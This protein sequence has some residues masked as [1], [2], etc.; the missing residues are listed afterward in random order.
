MSGLE[1]AGLILGAILVAIETLKI[2]SQGIA[3]L[4]RSR[5]YDYELERLINKL[6]N[7]R[8]R[9][10]DVCEKVLVDLVPHSR[11]EDLIQHPGHLF[12]DD[13][14]LKAKLRRR[15]WKGY[16]LFDQTLREINATM[17][18]A[19]N[20]ISIQIR[21]ESNVRRSLR[22][23][24]LDGLLSRINEGVSVLEQ[25]VNRSIQLEPARKIRFQG[26]FLCYM[27]GIASELFAVLQAG[28]GCPCEHHLGL[29]LEKRT[30]DIVPDDIKHDSLIRGAEFRLSLS[31]KEPGA[32][33]AAPSSHDAK[34]SD[35]L[36]KPTP[37]ARSYATA[38]TLRSKFEKRLQP[39]GSIRHSPLKGGPFSTPTDSTQPPDTSQEIE[40]AA[41]EEHVQATKILDLCENIRQPFVRASENCFGLIFSTS[42]PKKHAY[43]VYP[44]VASKYEVGLG[45]TNQS[46]DVYTGVVM[47]L[48][49]SIGESLV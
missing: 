48:E 20:S 49:K 2:G 22:H 13:P 44:I 32:S 36:V 47:P 14:E 12:D 6:E 11:I 26:K 10:G 5:R 3:V 7:E 43:D 45:D 9:L 41:R 15:L 8:V 18:E 34:W 28:F 19:I 29:Q 25:L 17:N 21:D 30:S 37:A 27:R 42:L 46:H 31:Y 16:D 38:Q 35:V 1:I 4:R 23:S 24:F 33:P 39:S 40:M